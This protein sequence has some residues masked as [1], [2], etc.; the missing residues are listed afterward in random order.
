M[1]EIR[2]RYSIV[3]DKEFGE[4]LRVTVEENGKEEWAYFPL[5]YLFDPDEGV[6]VG[7]ELSHIEPVDAFPELSSGAISVLYVRGNGKYDISGHFLWY[8]D[9]SHIRGYVFDEKDVEIPGLDKYVKEE[10][11]E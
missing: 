3:E 2:F 10:G 5:Y 7:A 1:G 6:K 8:P 11:N 4:C 9:L